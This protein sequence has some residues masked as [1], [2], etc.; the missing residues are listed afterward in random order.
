M[1]WW[2]YPNGVTV[3]ALDG[4]QKAE[5]LAAEG[6]VQVEGPAGEVTSGPETG[7]GTPETPDPAPEVTSTPESGSEGPTSKTL[8]TLTKRELIYV[9]A[10]GG[11]QVAK[12]ATNDKIRAAI[13]AAHPDI[14]TADLTALFSVTQPQVD[15]VA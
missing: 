9:A 6:C 2:R 8:D 7:Q 15:E 14:A 10:T 5:Y 1:G 13:L 4:G 11:V 12:S 3:W